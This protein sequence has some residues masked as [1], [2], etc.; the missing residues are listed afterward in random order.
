MFI[1]ILDIDECLQTMFIDI[2]DIDECR[3]NPCHVNA[4]CRND[5]GSYTCICKAG[6]TGGANNSC[7]GNNQ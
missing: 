4:D 7:T 2:L 3:L 6:Y 1:V 5:E